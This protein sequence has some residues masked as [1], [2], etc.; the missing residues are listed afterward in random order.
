[1]IAN[2]RTYYTEL[3]EH[4]PVTRYILSISGYMLYMVTSFF[5]FLLLPLL[6]ILAS[7]S[8][9]VRIF[10]FKK[11]FRSYL[12]FLTRIYLPLVK[13]YRVKEDPGAFNNRQNTP[14]IYIAN[15]RSQLDGPIILS[16]LQNA[17][18]IM[19]TAYTRLP[20]FSSFVKHNDFISVDASSV[21]LLNIA[22]Q[23]S[24]ELIQKG[25]NLLVFPEGSR[26]RTSRLQPFKDLA[27]R[28]SIE[29][30]TPIVPVIVHTNFPLLSKINKSIIPPVTLDLTI[31]VLAPILAEEKERP[32]DFAERARRIM[33]DEIKVLDNNTY[34][35]YL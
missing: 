18:V 12:F 9:K 8:L 2:N 32:A 28:L 16:R 31:K 29:T 33:A 25:T 1:M 21:E 35:E 3:Y 4:I 24:N 22:L 17:G 6:V 14:C 27:F 7:L 26:A 19:K 20:V 11:V 15:H 13:V 34:W 5:F 30:N 10:V 23:R